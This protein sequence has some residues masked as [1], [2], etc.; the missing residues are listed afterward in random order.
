MAVV[1][2]GLFGLLFLI[3][4]YLKKD[5]EELNVTRRELLVVVIVAAALFGMSN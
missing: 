4:C 1:Y 3:E 2:L 5:I